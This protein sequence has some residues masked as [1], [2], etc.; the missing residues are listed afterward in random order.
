LALRRVQTNDTSRA[1]AWL[2]PAAIAGC[3]D[4][5]RPLILVDVGC[6]AGLNL[7]GDALPHIWTT[8]AGGPL[9]VALR[10]QV[11]ARF[12]LDGRPLEVGRPDDARWLHACVWPG[13]AERSQRL[14]D[15]IAALLDADLRPFGDRPQCT[16]ASSG[17]RTAAMLAVAGA[18]E[19]PAMRGDTAIPADCVSEAFSRAM[20]THF[21]VAS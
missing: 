8:T 6:S 16:A 3:S 13:E 4:G 11:L 10:P 2:W 21:N 20:Q 19:A 14:N 7:I 1:L 12:G 18:V 17:T 5:G 15:A 9:G